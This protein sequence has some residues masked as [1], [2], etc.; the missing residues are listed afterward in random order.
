MV[1]ESPVIDDGRINVAGL[2]SAVGRKLPRIIA[3]TLALLAVTFVILMF[4]PRTY[5]GTAAVL[6]EPRQ[7]AS[8]QNSGDA[9]LSMFATNPA[10][11]VASQIQLIKSPD[12]LMRVIDELDL[13][14]VPEFSGAEEGGFDLG[15]L[16]PQLVRRAETP[17]S[18]DAQVLS[19][20]SASLSVS[21]QPQSAVIAI[22]VSS[23]DPQLAAQIANAIAKAH[24]ERR[25]GLSLSDNVETSGWLLE[26]IDRLRVSVGEAER[27]VA[28]F[29]VANDLYIGQGNTSLLDQRL[30]AIAS[31]ISAAQEQR[32]NAEKRAALIR[33][34]IGRNQPVESLVDVQS[35]LVVQ[36]L[37]Q[38]KARIQSELAQRSATLL[39]SHPTMR[40]LNAQMGELNAQVRAEAQRMAVALEAEAQIYTDQEAWLRADFE[41][42]KNTASTATI[43]TVTLDSLQREAKSQR[44]LLEAYLLRYNA[45]STRVDINSELPDVRVVTAAAAA[46]SPSAPKTALIMS[47]VAFVSIFCQI[48]GAIFGE[49]MSGRAL[50]SSRAGPELWGQ[51]ARPS[52]EPNSSTGGD[53]AE[54]IATLQQPVLAGAASDDETIATA[55]QSQSGGVDLANVK[56]MVRKIL[57][58]TDQNRAPDASPALVEDASVERFGFNAAEPVV[59]PVDKGLIRYDELVADLV[60]GRTNLLLLTDHGAEEG[61]EHLAEILVADA[62]AKGLSVALVDAG[63]GK[64]TAAPGLSDLT[65][66]EARFGDV[67]QKSADNSFAEVSWGRHAGLDRTSPRPV[68][69]IEA[70]TDIYEVVV[71][72]TGE[73]KT[74]SLLADFAQVG[75]RVVLVVGRNSELTSAFVARQKLLEAGYASVDVAAVTK[76][77]AA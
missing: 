33:D 10:G 54:H 47:A 40:A 44:D 25:A 77:V 15:A 64:V 58:E 35:S 48:G 74:Q 32:G 61:G 36:Q 68:T 46:S 5:E 60:L 52:D 65:L 11:V 55:E 2:L 26:E 37:S 9:R 30:S 28:D 14:S 43:D 7:S 63:S 3:V 23:R 51:Q 75:G 38:E 1:Y 56:E 57:A 42:A 62:L 27:A 20:L 13:R 39:S 50:V 21:Q 76:S 6:V 69:L 17:Q 16:L 22:T 18:V 24:V 29:K 34:V 67:V 31:Q 53:L 59:E 41:A 72:L 4:V 12:T 71:V 73:T 8:G 49:L 19:A 45:S 70:L 66:G